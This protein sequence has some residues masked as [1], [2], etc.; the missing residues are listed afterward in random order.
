MRP[1]SVSWAALALL[2]PLLLPAQSGQAI[3]LHPAN[4]HYLSVPRQDHCPDH[5]RRTLW[6][7]HQP[8]LRLPEVPGHAGS[9]RAQLHAG[10]RRQLRGGA[11][12]EAALRSAW[13][14][15]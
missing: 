14:G 10:L 1:G 5:Q 11:R 6:R 12:R 8:G 9:G 15:G 4:P 7:G 13:P 2:A 3:R